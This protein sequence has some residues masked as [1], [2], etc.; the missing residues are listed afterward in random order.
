MSKK[1]FSFANHIF[2]EEI[3]KKLN[4]CI[5]IYKRDYSNNNIIKKEI[6]ALVKMYNSII[7]RDFPTPSLPIGD[8]S[9]EEINPYI[10]PKTI[11][12]PNHDRFTSESEDDPLHRK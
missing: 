3:Y 12:Y 11:N 2:H 8:T 7:V 6:T 9:A 4:D 1:N 5:K 10:Q